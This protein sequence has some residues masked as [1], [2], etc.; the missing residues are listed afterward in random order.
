[1]F[2]YTILPL[3]IA[4]L[5]TIFFIFMYLHFS[6][7]YIK[8]GDHVNSKIYSV[9]MMYIMYKSEIKCLPVS[10]RVIGYQCDFKKTPTCNMYNM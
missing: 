7:Y 3:I 9:K 5:L 2:P 1:M 6:V 4:N 10:K 8:T